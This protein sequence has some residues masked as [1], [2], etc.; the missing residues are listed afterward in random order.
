MRPGRSPVN[1]VYAGVLLQA[2]RPRHELGTQY[3]RAIDGDPRTHHADLL[4]VIDTE[5]RNL[6]SVRMQIAIDLTT[7]SGK[8]VARTH[9]G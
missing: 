4:T 3:G 9:Y 6:D 1:F 7:Y 2:P 8:L 5:M